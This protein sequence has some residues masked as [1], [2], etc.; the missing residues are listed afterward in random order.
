MHF[1][2][3]DPEIAWKSIE[4]Y[5]NELVDEQKALDAFYRQ[6]TCPMCQGNCHKETLAAHVFADKA[7]LVQR[8]VLRCDKC[9]CLFDPHT[10]LIIDTESRGAVS[11]SCS[12]DAATK[13]YE[14]GRSHQE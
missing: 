11:A 1:K 7:T 3:L 5:H 4:G 12:E 9:K 6:F 8:S 2:T 10:G 14:L 13:I